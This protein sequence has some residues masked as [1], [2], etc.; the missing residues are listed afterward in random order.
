M[1]DRP[2][3]DRQGGGSER[4][5]DGKGDELTAVGVESP[6]SRNDPT[7]LVWTRLRLFSTRVPPVRPLDKSA[8][9]STNQPY[10]NKPALVL[11]QVPCDCHTRPPLRPAW[12]VAVAG[13]Q[14]DEPI[15]GG[16]RAYS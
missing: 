2:G 12:R 5:A 14:H 3:H 9:V 16:K 8:Q 4:P 11:V 10:I 15:T 7:A 6:P 13:N 1:R